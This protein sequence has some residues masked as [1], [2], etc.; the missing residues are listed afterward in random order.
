MKVI[1]VTGGAGSGKSE[2]LHLLENEFGAHV[3]MADEVARKLSEKGGA[4][5]DA[6]VSY[7]G[8]G[9]L[10]ADEAIDRKKL[11]AIVFDHPNLLEKLNSFTHPMVKTAIEK[12]IA[13]VRR[14]GECS[15]IALEAALLIEAGYEDVCDEFWYVYTDEAIRRQRMKESRGYSD[16]KIDSIIRN[17][18]TEGQFKKACQRIIVNNTTLAYVRYQLKKIVSEVTGIKS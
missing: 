2:V 1:G 8:C 14:V 10:D 4:S 12:E 17:Q 13:D 15:F 3:I 16:E 7:F 6:I 9:I 5:Y 18:L 11:A